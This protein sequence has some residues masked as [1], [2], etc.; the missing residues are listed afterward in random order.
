MF[1]IGFAELLLIGVVG[2]LVIGPE[3]L[4][5]AVRTAG[6]WLGRL[7]RSFNEVK[8]D[9]ERELR[10]DEIRQTL[11]NERV[12]RELKETQAQLKDLQSPLTPGSLLCSDPGKTAGPAS[13]TASADSSANP[14]G[15]AEPEPPQRSDPPS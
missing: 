9:I 2:L 11:H 10:T 5:M 8:R 12:L 7:R 14:G 1:D 15:S 4:P 3:R 6:L 13:P